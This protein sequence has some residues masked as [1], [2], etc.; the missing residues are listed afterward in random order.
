M[1]RFVGESSEQRSIGDTKT[2]HASNAVAAS[3]VRATVRAV[4]H[5]RLRKW[6]RV[7]RR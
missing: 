4:G 2:S 6:S 1:S 5:V 7:A 3:N